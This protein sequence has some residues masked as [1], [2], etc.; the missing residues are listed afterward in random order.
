VLSA[1]FKAGAGGATG[2]SGVFSIFA[3]SRSVTI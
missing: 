3:A 2:A 1:Y